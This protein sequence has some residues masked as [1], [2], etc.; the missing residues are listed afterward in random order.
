LQVRLQSLGPE[1][2]PELVNLTERL[3]ALM[4]KTILYLADAGEVPRSLIL[5]WKQQAKT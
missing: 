4:E 3:E 2:T 1:E 5:F